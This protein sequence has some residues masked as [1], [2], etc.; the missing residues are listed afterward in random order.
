MTKRLLLIALLGGVVVLAGSAGAYSRP[1]KKGPGP[2]QN[3]GKG[4]KAGKDLRHAYDAL[5]EV[6][7][8]VRADK[9]KGKDKAGP[10]VTRLTDQAKEVYRAAHRATRDEDRFRSKELSKAANDAARGLLHQLRAGAPPAADL[11]PPPDV[12][13]PATAARDLLQRAYD[14]IADAG[15]GPDRGPGRDFLDASR[16]AY[17]RA[18]Q[19]YLD[20]DYVRAAE[21]ARGAEAW[22]HVGEHLL[23]AEGA[24]ARVERD[25]RPPPPPPPG[26]GAPPPPPPRDRGDLRGPPG[27]DAPPPPPPLP[28]Q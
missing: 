19:A 8:L 14:R 26:R 10:E 1:P 16:R 21:L 23:R 17:E 15:A 13:G 22:T 24:D 12:Q 3:A 7:L 18:R 5:T 27:R 9:G 4:D 20:R 11:P 6:S 25:R 28:R 2:D